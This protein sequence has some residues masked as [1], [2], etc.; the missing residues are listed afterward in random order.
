MGSP[1]FERIISPPA[2]SERFK[3]LYIYEDIYDA[4][5]LIKKATG[6]VLYLILIPLLT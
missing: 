2:Q 6:W 3:F 4:I 5:N 1:S